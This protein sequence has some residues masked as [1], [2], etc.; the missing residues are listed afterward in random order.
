MIL[1][2]MVGITV[3]ARRVIGFMRTKP[4]RG[5]RITSYDQNV[6]IYTIYVVIINAYI[7]LLG[8]FYNTSD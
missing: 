7:N 5:F 2:M 1:I 3:T 8:W 4:K 6:I